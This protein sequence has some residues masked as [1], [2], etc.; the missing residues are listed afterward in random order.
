MKHRLQFPATRTCDRSSSIITR[1]LFSLMSVYLFVGLFVSR[2]RQKLL[3]WST[4]NLVEGWIR[5]QGRA[6][7]V[8][9][10]VQP[11]SQD[12]LKS[13]KN[14]V[15]CSDKRK[16]GSFLHITEHLAA[17][18]P[19]VVWTNIL[20]SHETKLIKLL[21]P[22]EPQCFTFSSKCVSCVKVHWWDKTLW[23]AVWNNVG[24]KAALSHRD[25]DST[26]PLKVPV[27]SGTK[28]SAADPQSPVSGS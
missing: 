19:S 26:R 16:D 9:G 5:V 15:V 13:K 10:Q 28:T 22:V 24:P 27:L 6:C 18:A 14:L 7:Y 2:I 11:T 17:S 8:L 20:K 4:L 1:S 21:Q 12:E 23:P 25:M 3:N